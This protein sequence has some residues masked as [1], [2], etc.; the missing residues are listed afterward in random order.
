MRRPTFADPA[1][2][3]AVLAL[4]AAGCGAAAVEEPSVVIRTADQIQ[5]VSQDE[6]AQL[7]AAG[8]DRAGPASRSEAEVTETTL[9]VT[10][11]N[12]SFQVRLG[13]ALTVFNSCL[14]DAG[15]VFV[16]LPGQSDDPVAAD[17][18]YLAALIACNTES[19]I[20]GILAEQNDRQSS[21]TPEQ[22]TSI[23]ESGRSVFECLIDR[24]WDLGDLVPNEN[25][26]L[27]VSRFPDVPPERQDE[28]QRDLDACGWNDLDLG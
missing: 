25:G 22:K 27:T 10:E 6:A 24:G 21:L 7:L 4:V 19:G 15:F 14:G 8:A 26:I 28:F 18:N 20:S 13:T 11:A 17:P 3:I 16:G 2:L 9:S 5:V 12:R 1:R 23:N